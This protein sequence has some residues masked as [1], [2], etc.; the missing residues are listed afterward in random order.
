MSGWCS[1][2]ACPTMSAMCSRL[3]ST[4][5]SRTASWT[6][7]TRRV[8]AHVRL[9]ASSG[10][11]GAAVR[12][13]GDQL[14]RVQAIAVAGALRRAARRA[15][16][17]P[18]TSKSARSEAQTRVGRNGRVSSSRQ[19]SASMRSSSR[20]SRSS[21]RRSVPRRAA[22]RR[23]EARAAQRVEHVVRGAHAVEHVHQLGG[24]GALEGPQR[25]LQQRRDRHDA[26]LAVAPV[27]GGQALAIAQLLGLEQRP[28]EAH[29]IVEHRPAASPSSRPKRI[30]SRMPW[31]IT[32]SL[33]W[34]ASPVS[35]QP[36]PLER[37]KNAAT[38]PVL[39]SLVRFGASPTRSAAAGFSASI[40]AEHR[41]GV[42]AEQRDLLG[43]AHEQHEHPVL[44]AGEDERVR[45]AG[46]QLDHAPAPRRCRP[47]GRP[48]EERQ[49]AAVAR[50]AVGPRRADALGGRRPAAVGADHER[51][52]DLVLLAARAAQPNAARTARRPQHVDQRRC[53][54]APRRRPRAR[55]RRAPGRT[56]GAGCRAR[57]R[58]PR[59]AGSAGCSST[60]LA[61]TMPS[62]HSGAPERR[63]RGS[64]PRRC[65]SATEEGKLRCV[66]S[67]SEGNGERSTA[68]TRRPACARAIAAARARAA[69]ADDDGVEA[70][71][72]RRAAHGGNLVGLGP[73]DHPRPQGWPG[74][75]ARWG[76]TAAAKHHYASRRTDGRIVGSEKDAG[77]DACW[78]H[79]S[80][81]GRPQRRRDAVRTPAQGAL[82]GPARGPRARRPRGPAAA[83]AAGPRARRPRRARRRPGSAA[84]TARRDRRPPPRTCRRAA[85]RTPASRSSRA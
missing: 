37:R 32:G 78:L 3:R 2:A 56:P 5:P 49:P 45:R 79:A 66:E 67:V 18:G 21:A 73:R 1:R 51:A 55:S 10:A 28:V 72:C 38:L 62:W 65:I 19:T 35:A 36:G 47:A 58:C 84:T 40:A 26:R 17:P 11:A 46:A 42:L 41:V 59:R 4:S 27:V 8:V 69:G 44:G 57:S 76:L 7:T 16:P 39:R 48:V 23:R 12:L 77:S 13:G 53:A 15:R 70:L 68:S 22:V 33:K 6:A 30:A 29:R 64:A 52:A 61:A 9:A 74:Y 20:S 34:P 75:R 81:R 54:R 80:D 31:P 25:L 71:T 14:E 85:P 63:I 82:G 24:A 60:P 43:R 83:A 50:A